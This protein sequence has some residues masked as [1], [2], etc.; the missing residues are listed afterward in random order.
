M[1]L[2]AMAGRIWASSV[3]CKVADVIKA[4]TTLSFNKA[5][6]SRSVHKVTRR[7]FHS[8]QKKLWMQIIKY[9]CFSPTG[10]PNVGT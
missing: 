4:N 7:I 1:F 8:Y 3:V 5:P 6:T 9:G 2:E 10:L